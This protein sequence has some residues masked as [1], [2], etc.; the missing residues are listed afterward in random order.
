MINFTPNAW[1]DYLYWQSQDKKTL[2]RINKLIENCAR[3][4]FEGIGKPEPLKDNLSGYWSRRID[5]THRLVYK[6]T[7]DTL[8]IVAV[9]FHY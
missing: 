5:D 9:R 8:V 1:D 2:K 6:A 7:Q 3:T 4:P